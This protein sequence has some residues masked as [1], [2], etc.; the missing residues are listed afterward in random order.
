[1]YKVT[2]ENKVI[3][4]DENLSVDD[5]VKNNFT[6]IKPVAAKI[7]GALVDMSEIIFDK[8]VY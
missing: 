8:V 2:I 5:L 1:M 4:T 7:N 3:E 6:N